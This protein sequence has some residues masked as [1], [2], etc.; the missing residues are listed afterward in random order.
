MDLPYPI[1]GKKHRRFFHN[2]LIDPWLLAAILNDPE[3]AA[4]S[5]IHILQDNAIQWISRAIRRN[6]V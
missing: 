1:V 6:N 3:A 5:I 4:A 2:I